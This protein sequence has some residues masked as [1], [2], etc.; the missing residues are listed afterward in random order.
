M[1]LRQLLAFPLVV[2]L[3]ALLSAC[4]TPVSKDMSASDFDRKAVIVFS[5][6]HDL[7]IGDGAKTL[8]YLDAA[9]MSTRVWYPSMRDVLSVPVGSD[10][11]D[12]RGHLY[13]EEV[14]PGR[15]Q[16]DAWQVVTQNVRLFRKAT[17]PPLVFEAKA[18]E[19]IYLGNVHARLLRG[20][21]VLGGYA[22]NRGLPTVVDRS[23][24]DIPM[25]EARIPALKG[26]VRVALLPEG[27][28]LAESEKNSTTQPVYQGM[29][30]ERR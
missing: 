18:G 1:S 16:F 27:P 10:F 14:T 25:A 13:V 29:R 23:D 2:A 20:Q 22:A 7:E 21:R 11:T 4:G 3:T 15:H 8:L 24:Q 26:K 6:S 12:R 17:P 5:V 9:S 28:W 19:V 30:I